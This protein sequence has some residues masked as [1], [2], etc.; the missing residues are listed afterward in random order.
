MAFIVRANFSR[1]EGVLDLKGNLAGWVHRIVAPCSEN[2][3]RATGSAPL[4][5]QHVSLNVWVDFGV[6]PATY[7]KG[8][9]RR[10]FATDGFVTQCFF[11]E[12]LV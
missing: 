10:R 12:F 6:E 4:S 3:S 8:D 9:T 11:D 7:P 5:R 1:A 2:A